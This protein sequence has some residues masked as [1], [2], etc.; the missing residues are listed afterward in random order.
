M[1]SYFEKFTYFEHFPF[2]ENLHGENLIGGDHSDDAN[3]TKSASANHFEYLKIL[4]TQ[5]KL[6]NDL[7]N[8]FDCE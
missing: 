1:L 8:W 7:D 5:S 2:V 4:P 3:L 6:L